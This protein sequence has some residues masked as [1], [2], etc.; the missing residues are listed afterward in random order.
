MSVL[1]LSRV[2]RGTRLMTLAAAGA[3]I[4][5]CGSDQD[6]PTAPADLAL[7][8]ADAKAP[9]GARP[10]ARPYTV[11]QQNSKLDLGRGTLAIFADPSAGQIVRQTFV[12]GRTGMLGYLDLPVGCAPGV[13]L[14]VRVTDAEGSRVAYEVNVVVPQIVDGSI[15][16]VQLFDPAKGRPG[17]PIVRGRR[18]GFEL[19]AFAAVG[20]PQ[21]LGVTCGI[22]REVEG[23]N[24][25]RGS[26]FTQDGAGTTTWLA[27][28]EEDL[29]FRTLVR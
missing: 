28:P 4:A 1:T 21:P 14:N 7:A 2:R 23:N 17:I 24:Y 8:P 3:L 12:A 5:A 22:A 9:L 13:L 18:Y 6:L 26:L 27:R 15:T 20:E 19:R 25:A 16:T 11:D 10:L 29:A